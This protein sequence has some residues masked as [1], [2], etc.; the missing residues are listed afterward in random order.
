[1]IALMSIAKTCLLAVR[2]V[3]F[4]WPVCSV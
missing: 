1:M 3:V 2:Q 4:S